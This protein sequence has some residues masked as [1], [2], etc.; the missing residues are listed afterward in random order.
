MSDISMPLSRRMTNTVEAVNA[1][2]EMGLEPLRLPPREKKPKGKWKE[3]QTWTAEQISAAFG[4]DANIGIALGARSGNL[5]DLDFDCREAAELAKIVC[6]D[7]PSFGRA[8]SPYSHRVA[9]AKLKKGRLT[10]E[11]PAEVAAALGAGRTMLME[12][13][14]T[15]HQTMFPP[16]IHPSGEQVQWHDDPGRIP[17]VEPGDLARRCGVVAALSAIAMAYPRVRGERD[18]ICFI[19]TAT[20]IRAGLSDGEIDLLIPVVASLAGDEEADRRGGKAEAV[21]ARIEAG[22]PAWG[23]PELCKRLGIEAL[24]PKL[25]G[26]LRLGSPSDVGDL[27]PRLYVRPGE[28]PGEVDQAEAALLAGNFGIYQRSGQLARV[29]RLPSSIGG[30]GVRR[31]GGIILIQD[32]RQA[33]LL[34]K[35]ALS[36]RW[37]RRGE[38]GDIPINPPA[39]HAAQLLARVGE[40]RAPVL[41]G[42]V[43]T[44]TMRRDGTIL[45]TPGFDPSSGLLFEPNGVTYPEV[46]EAPTRDQALEARDQL[47]RPFREF[48]FAGRADRSVLL[49]TVITSLIRRNLPSAP[50]IAIDAPTAGSGKSLLAETVGIIAAGHKPTMMS[51]GKSAE[52]DE[53]RLS[54]VLMAGDPV[55]VIDNC[56]RP[57][58]GDA[59]CTAL[60]Q[61]FITLRILGR[62]EVT[63]MPTNTLILA[64]GNNLEVVGDLGRRT[65]VIR[66]DTGEERPDQIEHDFDPR[67]EVIAE[68]PALVVAGLT[69]LRAY[70]TAGRPQRLAPMGSFEDWN[71]VREALVWLGE[72]DPIVTRERV[73]ADDPRK[74]ELADLLELWADALGGRAVTLAEISEEAAGASPG[75]IARLHQA[76]ADR[77]KKGIF[78]ATSIGRYLGKQKDRLVGGRVLRC[79]DDPSGVKRYRLEIP[80]APPVEDM[81]F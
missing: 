14:G 57:L 24:M 31:A 40:W 54:S 50:M 49:A 3:P 35:F 55:L 25:R 30:D 22:E 66:I 68:R 26:W 37:V 41:H 46:P 5:V 52:E 21:R 13:R 73:I 47:F 77:T 42:V 12:V 11:L 16:S 56:E 70:L 39:S 28:M 32:V 80:G 4:S 48:R 61:E 27:R 60:T 64:T 65:L 63:T 78:S 72:E 2:V 75:K 62:S 33:W 44:P 7:L 17:T 18:E 53:K 45:Q 67:A 8:S 71:V 29:V 34:E 51:Q 23:L 79:I 58:A 6:A 81:P 69:I 1:Y 20:L 15:G 74:G 59:L 19:L 76:L 38:E 10:F 36:A 43:S 9:H